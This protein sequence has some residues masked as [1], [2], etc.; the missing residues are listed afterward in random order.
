MGVSASIA[1]LAVH[2]KGSSG[3]MLSYIGALGAHV[4]AS[5]NIS[6]IYI[7]H[8]RIPGQVAKQ[9]VVDEWDASTT[10]DLGD[11]GMIFF[12]ASLE[13]ACLKSALAHH[14]LQQGALKPES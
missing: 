5:R 12:S 7:P 11:A 6:Y 10:E 13:P 3:K 9:P 8:V 14:A 1:L 4:V 2:A